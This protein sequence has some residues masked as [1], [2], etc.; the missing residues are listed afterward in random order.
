MEGLINFYLEQRANRFDLPALNERPGW[1]SERLLQSAWFHQRLLRERLC[2]L[3]GRAVRVLH[4]GFWNREAG[5][6]FRDAMLQIGNELPSI[7]DVEIDLQSSGWHEHGHDRNPAFKRVALHVVWEGGTSETMPVLVLKDFLDA[8]LPELALWLGTEAADKFPADL[9][10]RCA[11]PL[12][13]LP[14]DQLAEL[15]RQAALARLQR[16]AADLEARARQSGWEQSLWEGLLRALGYKHNTWPMLRLAE[17]RPVLGASRPASAL[18][19]QSRLFGVSGLLPQDLAHDKGGTDA[20][21]RQIWDAWWR[22]R[23]EFHEFI[24]PRS[25][26]HLA[27]IRPANHPV[28]RLALASCWWSSNAL[29]A[30]L[31][32]WFTTPVSDRELAPSLLEKLQVADDE[33]WS[34]HWTF[35]SARMDNPQPLLGERRATD[36]AI[37]VLLPWFWVRAK[38]GK[39]PKL[40]Q[41]AES[42]YL[43][44]PPAQDNA[45]LRLARQRLLGG[46][47]P[48]TMQTAAMQQG[49]MQIVRDYCNHS[50]ALCADCPFPDLVKA[51]SDESGHS[52]VPG[53]NK[54]RGI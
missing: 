17:L 52:N 39:N 12:S 46:P 54:S 38:E 29:L 22:E 47:M 31:E 28:R 41:E 51:F 44:W 1:P 35:R 5:P 23:S 49:L 9:L 40:M 25:L 11:T 33:F 3:D 8:P 37:N 10:G 32:R 43:A 14:T 15:L 53:A 6:D 7:G 16:K 45:V 30:N 48:P 34:R 24:L 27:G 36:L 20:Y 21:L 19:W 4:P 50:N 42:R 26:W 13:R 18:A 2:T